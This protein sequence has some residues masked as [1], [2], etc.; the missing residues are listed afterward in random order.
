[1]KISIIIPSKNGLHHLKE[2]LPSVL[3]A[4][5]N[6]KQDIEV[7]VVDDNSAD[8]TF[9][10]L[11]SLFPQVKC[12]QNPRAGI[13]SARNQGVLHSAGI[14]LLFL[15][16]DVF[17]EETFFQTLVKYF[18]PDVFCVACAGYPVHPAFEGQQLDG[19]KLLSWKRGFPRFTYNIFEPLP[20]V[21]PSWGVQG[22]YFAC[23]REQFEQLNG[24]DELFSPYMLEESDFVYRGLKRGWQVVYAAD[25]QPRHKCGGTI[26]SKKNKRTQYLSLRNRILFVWKNIHSRPMFLSHL[27]WLLLKPNFKLWRE[28]VG[29][30]PQIKSRR[31]QEK[32]AAVVS[33]EALFG[34]AQN[35]ADKAR[36][37]Q[38]LPKKQS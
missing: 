5:N 6:A 15:D 38:K 34:A 11:P 25:T 35:F 20:G 30:L 24:F 4:I 7:I 33:D 22:A 36:A 9:G 27:G 1:M 21:C 23:N 32:K 17:L 26:N 10:Q 8:N 13:C 31:A 28:C 18:Q 37:A 2:C 19:I 14:W 29:M 16:N 12:I 3:A